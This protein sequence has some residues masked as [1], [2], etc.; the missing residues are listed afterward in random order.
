MNPNHPHGDV[1][2][3]FGPRRSRMKI[4]LWICAGIAVAAF[5][6]YSFKIDIED[7]QGRE[8]QLDAARREARQQGR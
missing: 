8:K 2:V 1:K 5:Y 3:Q 6:V 4:F 7:Q